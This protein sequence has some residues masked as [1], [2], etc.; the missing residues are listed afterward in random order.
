MGVRRDGCVQSGE[1]FHGEKNSGHDNQSRA[2][3]VIHACVS[4]GR[5]RDYSHVLRD[6]VGHDDD[7]GD[8]GHDACEHDCAHDDEYARDLG[9]CSRD[10]VGFF[11]R[12]E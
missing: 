4:H 7:G 5:S 6:V 3:H 12:R 2:N 1:R 9:L 11:L 8:Q 10:H